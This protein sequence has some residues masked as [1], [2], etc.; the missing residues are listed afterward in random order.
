MGLPAQRRQ[1]INLYQL[2]CVVSHITVDMLRQ[3]ASSA[4]RHA[5]R[6]PQAVQVRQFFGDADTK[7]K[8]PIKFYGT[9][10]KY[11]EALYSAATKQGKAALV[12]TE[13]EKVQAMFGKSGDLGVILAD[14]TVAGGAKAD[15][16]MTLLKKEGMDDITTNFFGVMAANN[17]LNKADKIIQNFS[18]MI[19]KEKGETICV[20]TTT[21]PLS[22]AEKTDC[23]QRC[24]AECPKGAKI[25]LIEEVDP[26]MGGGWTLQIDEDKMLDFSH[27]TRM[28]KINMYINDVL[29]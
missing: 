24:Q 15:T 1:L 27:K 28:T 18:K 29:G 10:G 13:V 8:V 3:L 25:N 23:I 14:P 7:I 9:E 11:S 2:Q 12:A 22:P 20:V 4:A 21:T 16:V 26:N 6:A 17:R 19:M 5:R